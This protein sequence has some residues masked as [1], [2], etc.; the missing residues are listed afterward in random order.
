MTLND[1]ISDIRLHLI[2]PD[3]QSP[4]L[5]A[6]F[7]KLQDAAQL[8]HIE[9]QNT[10]TAWDVYSVP[11]TTAQDKSDY[12]ISA[13]FFGKDIRIVTKDSTN[14]QHVPREVRRCDL[15]DLDQYYGG[16]EKA[17]SSGHTAVVMAF[18]RQGQGAWVKIVPTPADAKD[19]E[20]WYEGD[21][22]EPLSL[23]DS[24]N[25]APF[26]RYRNLKAAISLIPACKWTGLSA[27]RSDARMIALGA[28]LGSQVE[29]YARAYRKYITSDRQDGVTVRIGYGEMSG[30]DYI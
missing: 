1:S 15:Q 10:S 25:I 14:P 28:S 29:D 26:Q 6:V 21:L 20:I 5:R 8:L 23:G 27:E 19:Y 30:Y 16:P 9:A 17:L 24:P 13:G 4:G 3:P 7:L 12:L 11:L 22:S 2:E 18:Y